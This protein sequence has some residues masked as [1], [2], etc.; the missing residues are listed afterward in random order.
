[1]CISNLNR[2]KVALDFFNNGNIK[3]ARELYSQHAELNQK[4]V[5]SRRALARIHTQEKKFSEAIVRWNEVANLRPDITEVPLRLGQLYKRL[6]NIEE[7]L[8][9]YS[10]YLAFKPEH[11]ESQKSVAALSMQLKHAAC[12]DIETDVRHLAIAGVSYCGSTILSHVLGNMDGVENVGESHRLIT[13]LG[14]KTHAELD[15]DRLDDE[16]TSYCQSCGK[17]CEVYTTEFRKQLQQDPTNWYFKIGERVGAKVLLSS[18]KNHSKL[19]A[20][21][22]YLRMDTIVLF[23]SPLQAWYSNYR[24][25]NLTEWGSGRVTDIDEYLEK[26]TQ[27]YLRFDGD[28][29]PQGK[30]IYLDFEQFCAAPNAHLDRLCQLFDLN[31]DTLGEPGSTQH[32]FGG[33]RDVNENLKAT[34]DRLTVRKISDVQLPQGHK[35]HIEKNKKVARIYQQMLKYYQRDFGSWNFN[36]VNEALI[37]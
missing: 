37:A 5:V 14:S 29:N 28:F 25:I 9:M 19:L 30:K 6:G 34:S 23:K 16:T 1:M 11:T 33:N 4:C 20:K 7:S 17:D 12:R 24:K 3:D 36:A 31:F 27:A 26:W 10:Q 15:F 8:R 2:L 35:R 21:D 22:P 13:Q 32:S 18:D